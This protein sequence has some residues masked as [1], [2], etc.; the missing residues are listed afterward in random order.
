MIFHLDDRDR[1]QPVLDGLR[2][3][4]KKI[5]TTNGTFDILHVGHVRLFREA[6]AQGDFLVLGLNSDKS[7]KQY[8]SEL[9]PIVPQ[10]ERA[11]VVESIRY[12]DMVLIF[13]EP[14]S[15]RF[16]GEVKPDVHVKDSTYGTDLIEA[17]ILKRNG[18]QL[19][20]VEKDDHS[21]TDII[22]KIIQVYKD[23]S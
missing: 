6:R 3:E 4:G 14:E 2:D 7:V 23:E 20:L 10:Q 11:V 16:V 22:E 12:V 15:L 18:G 17:P 19:Y 13:D 21:T 1:W 9:R 8:K 5:V